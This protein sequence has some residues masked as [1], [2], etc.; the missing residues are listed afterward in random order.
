VTYVN[1]LMICHSYMSRQVSLVGHTN[2]SIDDKEI[3]I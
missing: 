1:W 2:I 3:A